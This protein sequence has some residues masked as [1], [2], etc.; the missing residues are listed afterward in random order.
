MKRRMISVLLC[1][2]MAASLLSGAALAADAPDDVIT[3][4][5]TY[6][7]ALGM[8]GAPDQEQTFTY[9][10]GYFTRSGY[11]YRQDLAASSL[12]LAMAAFSSSGG[13]TYENASRNLE[14]LL[15]KCGFTGFAV[16]EGF[17]TRPTDDSIGVGAAYKT[18]RDNGG[19]YTLVAVGV[20]GHNY[21]GEWGGNFRVGETGDHAGFVLC[22]DQ[23]LAFLRGYLAE[24]GVTG[25]IKLWMA[26]YS[27][28]AATVNLTAA[29]LDAGASL[30]GQVRL[31]RHDLYCYCFEPPMGTTAA[32]AKA[33][34]YGNIHNVINENDLVPAVLPP[35][36][37]F[38]RY[39]VDHA[40]PA[41]GTDADYAALRNTMLQEFGTFGL[42]GPYLIDSFRMV[43]L[44]LTKLGTDGAVQR[45]DEKITQRA[46]Y[47]QLIEAVLADMAATRAD[48]VAVLQDDLIELTGTIFGYD[49]GSMGTALTLFAARISENADKLLGSLTLSGAMENGTLTRLLTQYLFES[50]NEAGVSDYD[51]QQVRDMAVS[52]AK[53]V[54]KFAVRH[55]DLAATLMVNLMT[56]LSAHF[57]ELCLSWMRTL[58]ADYMTGKQPAPSYDGLYVDV[59]GGAWYAADAAYVTFGNLMDGVGGGRFAPDAGMTR[60]MLATVLYRLEGEPDVSGLRCPFTDLKADWYRD[61]VTWAHRAGVVYGMSAAAFAPDAP[62]TREQMVAM[63]CRYAGC[64][65]GDDPALTGYADAGSV[66]AWAQTAMRWAVDRSVLLGM[67]DG[68][69]APKQGGTRAQVAA[70]LQRF[71]EQ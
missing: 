14:A 71:C 59:S 18:I 20:R 46:F 34:V 47:D 61:A 51:A 60:G 69:L 25:R 23:V 9:S 2:A 15:T 12:E 49:N 39:G 56:I 10:D 58:P 26:G 8:V 32:D 40:V 65:Q 42:A 50:L 44:D 33:P 57:P 16:N 70:V 5:F 19:D 43:R 29:A 37:G 67:P 64:E 30:G 21:G 27:R 1:L 35:R 11:T 6:C 38:T 62:V 66:S 54:T 24:Q 22:R 7:P 36:W 3:G 55:P 52:L 41:M 28:S 45:T 53:L 13:A 68:T 48:Y 63:L 31:S 4:T 17:R